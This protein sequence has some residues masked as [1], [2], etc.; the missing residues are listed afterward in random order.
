MIVDDEEQK[1]LLLGRFLRRS[2]PQVSLVECGNGAEAIAQ[3]EKGA[4]DLVITDNRMEPVSGIE[5]TRWIRARQP[6]LPVLMVT[7]HPDLE[8]AA[9]EAGAT[10]LIDF[11][12]YAEIGRIVAELLP[13]RPPS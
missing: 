13:G 11:A 9:R 8:K 4:V 2:F 7:G 3:L 10:R 5:L 12:R 6:E 1:R